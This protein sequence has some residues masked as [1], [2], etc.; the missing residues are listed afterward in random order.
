MNLRKYLFALGAVA[1]SMTSFSSMAQEGIISLTEAKEMALENN[2]K[3]KRMQQQVEAARSAKLA[4]QT[5]DKPVLDGKISGLYVAK[6]FNTLLPE[7]SASSTLGLNQVIYAGRKIS[8]TKQSSASMLDLQNA[9]KS[10]TITEVLLQT[11]SAYWQLVNMK[12]KRVLAQEYIR[13]LTSLLKDLNNSYQVGLIYKNDLLRVQV[14]LNQAELNLTKALNGITMARL[15]LAQLTGIA[16]SHLEVKDNPEQE[17][18]VGL[19][20]NITIATAARP[21]IQ[22]LNKAVEIQELQSKILNADRKPTVALSANGL[23]AAGKKINFSNGNNGMASFYGLLSV[24]IPIF[25]W[26]NRKQKVKEQQFKASAQRLELDEAKETINL[27]IQHS[28]LELKQSLQQIGLSQ[29][30]LVQAEENLRLNNDRFKAGTVIGQDVLEAQVLWQQALSDIIDAKTAFKLSESR[31]KK[32]IG[33][34]Q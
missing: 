13:L 25:D 12:E 31:Y 2:K 7:W 23:Y 11:E 10:L 32:A 16:E 18:A 6:P 22:M 20:E 33:T 4:A 3:I 15:N 27:E 21:E 8:Y 34:L 19:M 29:K 30:S 28:Y 14:Q 9:Q 1:M 17:H 24:N 5:L 26:G